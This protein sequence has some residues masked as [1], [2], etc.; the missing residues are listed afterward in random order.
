[1]VIKSLNLTKKNW[2]TDIDYFI[3]NYCNCLDFI[4]P[5]R[6]IIYEEFLISPYQCIAN[7]GISVKR[8]KKIIKRKLKMGDHQA[9]QDTKVIKRKKKIYYTLEE[10]KIIVNSEAME[11]Y[12]SYRVKNI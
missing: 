6:P 10:K 7:S 8:V 11:R 1:M 4:N 2:S 9:H 12:N 3:K 5:N